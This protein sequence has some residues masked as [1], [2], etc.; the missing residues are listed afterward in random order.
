MLVCVCVRARVQLNAGWFI[1]WL[2][3]MWGI[4]SLD[5]ELLASRGVSWAVYEGVVY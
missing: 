1:F 3:E 5:R 2:H 4:Y